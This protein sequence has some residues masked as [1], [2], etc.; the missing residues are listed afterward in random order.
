MAQKSFP[1]TNNGTGDGTSGGYTALEWSELWRKLFLSGGEASGGVLKGVDNELAVSGTSSPLSV[2]TGAAVVYGKLYQ[3][4][5]AVNLNVTTPVVGTTGGHVV[6]QLDWVAQTV[7]LVATRNTDGVSSTPSLTQNT[8]TYWEIRLATFTINTSGVITVTDA[9]AYA[10]FSQTTATANIE[11]SAVTTA[12]INDA[13]VTTAK[14]NNAAVTTAKLATDSVDDTIAGNRVAVL[15]RRQGGDAT[16]WV[17]A[18][19]TNYTPTGVR[20]QCGSISVPSGVTT[21][22]TFPVAFS[23]RPLVFATVW[24]SDASVGVINST[25]TQCQLAQNT[26]GTRVMFW[27]A[28][29]PE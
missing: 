6:L 5:S 24:T 15:A 16:D 10:H 13:A 2:G 18:G 8:S 20:I 25:A 21:T 22:V 17:S 9:R 29:G 14:I 11:D 7:R 4:T 26:G 23:G 3:N 19:T 28:I 27:L 1:F 12:K